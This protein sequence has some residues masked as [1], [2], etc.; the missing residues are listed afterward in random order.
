M[1]DDLETCGT[2]GG[3]CRDLECEACHCVLPECEM[4]THACGPIIGVTTTMKLQIVRISGGLLCRFCDRRVKEAFAISRP[5]ESDS[6]GSMRVGPRAVIC[7][8]CIDWIS[9]TARGMLENPKAR[10]VSGEVSQLYKDVV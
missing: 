1:S 10:R 6:S 9:D 7:E 8:D 5:D 4:Q 2:C 3:E